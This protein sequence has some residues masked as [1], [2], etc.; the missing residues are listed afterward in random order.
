STRPARETRERRDLKTGVPQRFDR[1]CSLPPD[2]G[3]FD[4][5]VNMPELVETTKRG[6]TTTFARVA[7][8]RLD[9]GTA[10]TLCA[11]CSDRSPCWRFPSVRSGRAAAR[12]SRGR[13][14]ITTNRLAKRLKI[15]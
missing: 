8:L 6:K 2:D 15:R 3:N 7:D 1:D 11:T 13:S 5:K 12:R 10:A 4:L 9:R 14:V